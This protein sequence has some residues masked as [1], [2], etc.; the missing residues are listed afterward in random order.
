[1][2]K[3]LLSQPLQKIQMLL[4][5]MGY[6]CSLPIPGEM[7]M[8]QRFHMRPTILVLLGFSPNREEYILEISATPLLEPKTLPPQKF[9][10]YYQIDFVIPIPLKI[11]TAG[12]RELLS[13]IQFL[14]RLL[15][16]PGF[17]L[18]ELHDQLSYRYVWLTKE[19]GWEERSFGLLL[20]TIELYMKLFSEILQSV[21]EGRSSVEALL[22]QV[23]DLYQKTFRSGTIQ[24]SA[25]AENAAPDAASPMD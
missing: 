11:S 19:S 16:W 23:L 18:D 14:N 13:L 22:E 3:K 8:C 24:A 6:E 1:M 12:R 25:S 7:E 10:P 2:G 17:V 9:S 5:K 4:K 21:G 20:G 15:D